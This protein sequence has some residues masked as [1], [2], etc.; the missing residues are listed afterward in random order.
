MLSLGGQLL[1]ALRRGAGYKALLTR[2]PA[3]A[4]ALVL[5]F[6]YDLIILFL[7]FVGASPH[8]LETQ[9]SPPRCRCLQE[10]QAALLQ[11]LYNCGKTP[12]TVENRGHYLQASPLEKSKRLQLTQN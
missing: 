5:I 4:S 2:A 6:F 12:G 1:Q 3:K 7:K 11:L 9:V 10:G 8:A